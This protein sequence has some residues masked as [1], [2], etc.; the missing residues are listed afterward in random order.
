MATAALFDYVMNGKGIFDPEFPSGAFFD[1]EFAVSGG[2]GTSIAVNPL[3][4]RAGGKA[5]NPTVLAA[6]SVSVTPIGVRAA[7]NIG[8]PTI[9]ANAANAVLGVVSGGRPGFATAIGLTGSVNAS[10]NPAGFVAGSRVGLLFIPS[11][12]ATGSP[13]GIVSGGRIGDASAI[14]PQDGIVHPLGVRI[15]GRFLTP[16]VGTGPDVS[17]KVTIGIEGK[18]IKQGSLRR[19]TGMTDLEFEVPFVNQKLQGHSN[20]VYHS[21]RTVEGLSTDSL[22]LSS[23]PITI[24]GN[25]T[26]MDKIVAIMVRA[27]DPNAL[28][29]LHLPCLQ[30]AGDIPIIGNSAFVWF[31]PLGVPLLNDSLQVENLGVLDV[32]YFIV[33]VGGKF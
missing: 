4:V 22:I 33:L 17:G 18:S 25:P 12:D 24:Y 27:P 9:L 13:I 30:L 6:T 26:N 3:G 29:H 31:A 14:N 8:F 28:L 20:R 19:A 2:G 5:T 32:D 16:G 23:L 11:G 7:G 10:V 15:G 1:P 21:K